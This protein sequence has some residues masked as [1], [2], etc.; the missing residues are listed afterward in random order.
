MKTQYSLA[1]CLLAVV[2]AC[3]SLY[4]ESVNTEPTQGKTEKVFHAT[5]EERGP[6][7]ATKVYADENLKV[8]W[9]AD[10]R[11]TIYNKYTYGY[12]YVFQGAT[13]DT[14]GSFVREEDNAEFVTGNALDKIYAVY[15][16]RADNKISN[17]GELSVHWPSSQTYKPNSFG[18]GSNVMVSVTTDK[19]LRFKNV[20]GYLA[21][22]LYGNNISVSS[23]LL[24]GNNGEKLTGKATISSDPDENPLLSF[25]DVAQRTLRLECTTP[26]PLGSTAESATIF[27]LVV[28]PTQFTEG[29]NITVRTSDGRIFEK[30]TSSNYT[31]ERNTLC[32]MAAVEVVPTF[33]TYPNFSEESDWGVIGSIAAHEMN[34]NKDLQMITDGN[35]HVAHNVKLATS[36]QF[37]V[38]KDQGWET[39]WG[40]PGSTAPFVI[41]VGETIDAT[42]DGNNFAVPVEGYYDILLDETAGNVTIYESYQA[43]PGYDEVSNWSVI[44]AIGSLGVCWNRDIPMITDGD[45]HVA[46]G[47]VLTTSDQFKFRVDHSWETNIGAAGAST[48]FVVRLGEVCDGVAFGQSISVPAD[49]IYDLLCNPATGAFQVVESYGGKKIVTWGTPA[50]DPVTVSGWSIFVVNDFADILATE[51]DDIWTVYF[52]A[53]DNT[54]FKWRKDGSWTENYGGNLANYGEPFAAIVNGDVIS[55]PAGFYKVVLDMSDTNAPT[56]TV[57]NDFEVW[58]LIG[59]FNSWGSDVDM[60][61]N[62]G[63]WTAEKVEL[64]GNWKIRKNHAWNDY[65]GGDFG[66]LAEPFGVTVDGNRIDCGEGTFNVIYNPANETI[67]VTS[68]E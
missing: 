36:D 54:D 44:G 9:N 68:A 40:A 39:N 43:Y 46:E 47:V 25:N 23:I 12:E 33:L 53:G 18:I 66:A 30:S 61:E 8:L 2:V 62:D 15:P 59:D 45:W 37:K 65:R 13:G 5:L 11:I 31:I 27:W 7:D 58:S 21:L 22:K 29:F 48:P 35:K 24:R 63:L 55:V 60:V 16:Y 10:D 50:P 34:W 38:R 49:G 52:A 28:P 3:Q 64:T 26:V 4:E 1:L 20:G 17:S 32:R 41:T 67:T 19:P 42:H 14:A 6:V 57:T 51:K 56:I